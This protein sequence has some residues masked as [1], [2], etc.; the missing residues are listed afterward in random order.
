MAIKAII[1]DCFG[2]LVTPGSKALANDYPQFAD[3]ISNLDHQADYGLISRREYTQALT[4]LVGLSDGQIE[5]KYWKDSS[6]RLQSSI[7]WVKQLRQSGYKVGLLSNIGL[8]FFNSYFSNSERDE[9]FDG[10]ILSSEEGIAKP[11]VAIYEM[12]AD[13]LG[14]KVDECIMVDDTSL[15]VEAAKNVGMQGVWFINTRQAKEEVNK[16]LEPEGA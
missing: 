1:F 9:L 11:D 5:T 16:I 7:E 6:V 15:N 8:G 13:K 12:M 10:V 2:V 14:V 4:A 3:E